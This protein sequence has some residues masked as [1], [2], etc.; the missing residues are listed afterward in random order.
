MKRLHATLISLMMLICCFSLSSCTEVARLETQA[1]ISAVGIDKGEN[2]RFKVTAQVFQSMGSGS[3]SPIDPSKSNTAVVFAEADTVSEAMGKIEQSLG[4]QINTGHTK[5]IVIGRELLSYPLGDILGS[6]IADE[7]TYL[8]MAVLTAEDTAEEIMKVQLLNDVETAVA[9]QNIIET[10]TENGTALE[11]DLL[12]AANS[13]ID[14]S[15]LPLPVISVE[16]SK[17]P[18]QKQDSDSSGS[19]GEAQPE[20]KFVFKGTRLLQEGEVV[21]VANERL[22]EGLCWL[23]G[24]IDTTKKS[25]KTADADYTVSLSLSRSKLSLT[26]DKNG[27]YNLMLYLEVS[28]RIIESSRTDVDYNAAA[29]K[30]EELIKTLCYD[31]LEALDRADN[32]DFLRLEKLCLSQYPFTENL[33]DNIL[34]DEPCVVSVNIHSDL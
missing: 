34:I 19:S 1:I 27:E 17:K 13:I 32:C 20:P 16:K 2:E 24:S 4:R 9:V 25:I 11:T 18:S 6:F 21:L 15:V 31:T 23:E 10:A 14:K 28:M 8:G 7:Q 5:Y 3:A 30:S 29:E 26:R 22:T 12:S 33:Y